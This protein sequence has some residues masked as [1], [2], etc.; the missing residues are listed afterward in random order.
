LSGEPV[1]SCA[2][3][4]SNHDSVGL[5]AWGCVTPLGDAAGTLTALLRGER[6][7][8]AVPVLGR[9]GGDPV[10]LGLLNNREL[11]ETAPPS[12]LATIKSRF[13]PVQ[14]G[15]WGPA[16]AA[17]VRHEQQFRGRVPLCLSP[18]RRS[19]ISAVWRAARL[20]GVAAARAGV[21]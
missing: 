1:A 15:G 6:A 21:G 18:Q 20:R 12:W 5:A 8:R 9:E 14:E 3:Y 7:L 13:G 17:G 16:A 19:G 4:S 10:P 2:V 11:D